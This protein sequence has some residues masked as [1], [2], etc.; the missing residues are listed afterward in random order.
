MMEW[1]DIG[2]KDP[3]DILRCISEGATASELLSWYGERI[4]PLIAAALDKITS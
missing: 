4:S 1:G 2:I 3:E